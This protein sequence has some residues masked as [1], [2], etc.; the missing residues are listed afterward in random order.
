[1]RGVE[2]LG[3][4]VS[5]CISGCLDVCGGGLVYLDVHVH[6]VSLVH[7][8]QGEGHV[9]EHAHQLTLAA[10]PLQHTLHARRRLPL[11]T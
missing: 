6:D 2:E 3:Q 4:A 7:V 11:S 1:V 8:V 9:L 5:V 10:H